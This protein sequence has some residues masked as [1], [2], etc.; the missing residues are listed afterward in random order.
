[1]LRRAIE[2]ASLA[3]VAATPLAGQRRPSV[4]SPP[5][6]DTTGYWQ[7]R[8]R[9]V[10]T[11]RLEEARAVVVA[12]GTLTY[13]NQSPDTLRVMY[14]HQYLNAFRPASAWSRA[15]AREGRVRFQNLKEPDF[16]YE[17]FTARPR[18]N[19]TEVTPEYP[20]APDSTVVRIALPR[21]LAP[22][23][24]LAVALAWEARPSTLPRRQGR[25]GRS[26][27]L[28]QWYPKVAVYD[29]GGWQPNPLVPAGEFYG[30]FGEYD[31]TIVLPG[32]QVVGATG[33]PVSGDPGWERVRRHG[34]VM[35]QRAAYPDVAT[36]D[37]SVGAGMRAVRFLARDVHHFAWSAS[38]EY[39]YEGGVYVR[40][41]ARPTRFRTWDTV[42]VHVLYRPGD[43]GT[44]GNGQAVQRTQQALAWLERVYGP[45]GYPQVTN[46]HR[47]EGGGTEFPMMMMNGSAGFGLILHEGGHIFTYG[48]LANNEW[49][50]G[51][52]D[53]GLTSYQT[54]WAQGQT[55]QERAASGAA[56]APPPR[57]RGYRGLALRPTPAEASAIERY[58]VDLLGRAEPIG[59]R[60]DLFNE[61]AIYN[62][63]IY[64]RAQAMYGA[65]RD[66]IGDSAF[67]RLLQTY[68]DR[69]AFRHVDE[70][71]MRRAAEDA[72]GQDLR[73][74]FDQWVHRVGLVDYSL[75]RLR[76]REEGGEWLTT[77]RVV[78]RG[79]YFHPVRLGVRTEAGWSLSPAAD[80]M[81][82][83]QDV[84]VRTRARPLQ[85]RIDPFRFADD[86]YA[87]ND[88]PHVP[89][90]PQVFAG[91]TVF[92][93]PF[94]DQAHATRI[95]NQLAP[96]FW[97]GRPGGLASGLRLR[98]N[99]QG[100][101][102]RTQLGVAVTA[103]QPAEPPN[104]EWT[105]LHVRHVNPFDRVQIWATAE[106]FRLPW[107]SQ[108]VVGLGVG[109]WAVDGI[110]KMDARKQW[111]VSRYLYAAGPKR[112]LS[113]EYSGAYPIVH[114]MLDPARWSGLSTTEV[115]AGY[116]A[117]QP[118]PSKWMPHSMWARGAVGYAS[119]R[120]DRDFGSDWF[121]RIE[122]A[123]QLYSED[124]T[125]RF[126]Y[127]G[128]L[129]GAL[130]RQTPL[131]R[132]VYYGAENAVSTFSNHFL[133]P[134][135]APLA[136]RNHFL[137]LGGAG[138]RGPDALVRVKKGTLTANAELDGRLARTGP[139]RRPLTFLGALW[140]DR[141]ITGSFRGWGTGLVIRG[142]LFDR[143]IRARV[144]F[145]FTN[146]DF[147]SSW[148]FSFSD[149]W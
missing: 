94:L 24:S 77:A 17:R 59:T 141:E 68:Y 130:V 33:V 115:S 67:T 63:M 133:R 110:L 57:A 30:E 44:W 50:S 89:G 8:V 100:W 11:A 51:W 142:H 128:R 123:T 21:P 126:F 61:F 117:W 34:T 135:G 43:E 134:D 39:R 72:S 80:P 22:G 91:R 66:V 75:R 3:L 76:I 58:R 81:N 87:P 124:T 56:P 49:Q 127:R 102:N 122:A 104:P 84:T 73:W 112:V 10:I 70:L 97:Y 101:V 125:A 26:F 137:P 146:R 107:Q 55:P 16:G 7:Q 116:A 88:K 78:K 25:R 64:T 121:S 28:A 52:M 5:S 6:G 60:S 23:D 71:A 27:D 95:L 65:L 48:I 147:G 103:D 32:D 145:P 35:L 74:F 144:D 31:V 139:A 85:V 62:A 99:Y 45:Y 113:L 79:E 96:I 38:P 138:F 108:P 114:S 90:P 105:G 2:A 53:E 143:A 83:S 82:W 46:L 118:H 1:M 120:A 13:V 41:A 140:L 36:E 40:S 47:L 14:F 92:D 149:L 111:D 119:G 98:T 12:N 20:G 106:D 37:A 148:T 93:W 129:Y 54:A 19:G 69:W 86:W 109:A 29:R 42:A 4:S 131:E 18:V 136:P 132:S 9:Y 15:D